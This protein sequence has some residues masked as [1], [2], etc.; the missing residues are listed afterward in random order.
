MRDQNPL[1]HIWL[2]IFAKTINEL[3]F[4]EKGSIIDTVFDIVLNTE[5]SPKGVL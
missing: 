5:E 1:K 4:P 2:G 3:Q